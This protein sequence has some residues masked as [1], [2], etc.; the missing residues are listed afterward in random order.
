[1]K[2]NSKPKKKN[3]ELLNKFLNKYKKTKNEF[4]YRAE[5]KG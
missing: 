5:N 1:M 2:R 4:T 3:I